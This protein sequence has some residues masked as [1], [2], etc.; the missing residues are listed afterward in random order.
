MR[1]APQQQSQMFNA[2]RLMTRAASDD[3]PQNLLVLSPPPYKVLKLVTTNRK[4]C[5]QSCRAF[6]L[7]RDSDIFINPDDRKLLE[8]NMIES[9][10]DD[11]V[12]TDD[13]ILEGAHDTC[14]SDLN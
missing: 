1:E 12:D 5:I 10:Q 3:I 9:E 7:F 14:L 2:P 11:D 13:D 6:E 8:G 4:T